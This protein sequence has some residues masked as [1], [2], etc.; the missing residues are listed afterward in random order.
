MPRAPAIRDKAE[1]EPVPPL[2]LRSWRKSQPSGKAPAA[3]LGVPVTR[4]WTTT[5]RKLRDTSPTLDSIAYDSEATSWG[6]RLLSF[7]SRAS[8]LSSSSPLRQ[9]MAGDGDGLLVSHSFPLCRTPNTRRSPLKSR[10]K[11]DTEVSGTLKR[12]G[13]TTGQ[14]DHLIGHRRRILSVLPHDE[15]V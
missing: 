8:S 15:L 4:D 6:M 12:Y 11:I 2:N 14:R 5:F 9:D 7:A 1:A 3:C 10:V 13:F